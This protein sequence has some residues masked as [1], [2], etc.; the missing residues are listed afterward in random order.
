[1]ARNKWFPDD[2]DDE[3]APPPLLCWLCGR[4]MGEVTEWH[5]PV[6]K[7]KGGRSKE[8]VHPICHQAIHTNFSNAELE[9]SKGDVTVLQRHPAV[10]K[11]LAWV[12]DKD[13]DF[14][15]PTHKEG[16]RSKRR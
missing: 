4:E 1:M 12:A 2:V 13:P 11:F 7:T 6:P 16:G 8:P 10:A 14:H 3:E 15:A 9:R 5:H